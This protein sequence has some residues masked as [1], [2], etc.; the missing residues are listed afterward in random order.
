[1]TLRKRRIILW[2]SALAFITIAPALLF[3]ANGYRLAENFRISK[4]G[5][6]YVSSPISGSEIYVKEELE[7][8]TNIFQSGLFLQS[9]SS[10]TYPILVAKDGFWPWVKDIKVKEGMVAETRAFLIP[11]SPEGKVLLRGNFSSVWASPYNKVLLLEEKKY[12]SKKATFYLPD[13]D[14][15]LIDDSASTA[16][17]LFFKNGILKISWQD[18]AIFLGADEEKNTIKTTLNLNDQTVSA[19]SDKNTVISAN[20]KYERFTTKKDQRLWWDNKTN[21]IWVEWLGDK[22]S[23][24]YYLCDAKPCENTSYLISVFHFPIKNADFFPGRKDLIIAAVQNS[25]FALEIDGRGG[26]LSRPIYKGKDPTFA[27]FPAEK[28]VYVL[29]EGILSAVN[30][31]Y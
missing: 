15:F 18:G 2:L 19:F 14:T 17:F 23:I 30:L 12:Q 26:R 6:L 24:P 1:M 10:G 27:V 28:K 31:E 4:T 11:Q 16:K 8:K 29:D 7:K 9:L 5:G 3:Y 21:E 20:E 13:T 25:V 22:N